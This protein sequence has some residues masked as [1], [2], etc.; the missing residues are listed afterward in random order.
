MNTKQQAK[1]VRAASQV[2]RVSS[3]GIKVLMAGGGSAK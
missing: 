3:N 1:P 2:K